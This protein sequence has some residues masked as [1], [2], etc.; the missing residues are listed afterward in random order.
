MG[1]SFG[2]GGRS[3]GGGS[4]S[5]GGGFSSGGNL[6]LPIFLGRSRGSGGGGGNDGGPERPGN[7]GGGGN[8]GCIWFMVAVWVLLILVLASGSFS[9]CSSEISSSSSIAASTVERQPLSSDAARQTGYYTDADGS[10]ISNASR[11]EDGM[12]DFYKQTGVWPYLYILPNGQTTSTSALTPKAEEL[13]D[14]LFNDEAHFLLVFC[15]NGKGG[16]NCGYTVGS[17]AKTIMDDEAIGIL[18]DYLDR[19]YRDMSLSEEEIFSKTFSKTADRIMSK[20]TSPVPFA[21]GGIAV[22]AVC[23]TVIYVVWRRNQRKADESKRMQEILNTPLEKFGDKDVED[24]A[25]KYEEET[26]EKGDGR[27]G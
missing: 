22:V 25:R 23:G 26:D 16:Y 27:S 3:F 4:S 13:Y 21:A 20:T 17:E 10:W 1:R 18:S 7:G 5:H 2:G 9:S 19:Y 8:K 24:L 6:F 12:R 14:Q 11:L 15:D